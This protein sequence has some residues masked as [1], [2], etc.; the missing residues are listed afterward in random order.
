MIVNLMDR[1]P[2]NECLRL[3][4]YNLNDLL[5]KFDMILISFK[6]SISSWSEL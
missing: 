3:A 1:I 4:K 2:D 5:D 6:R